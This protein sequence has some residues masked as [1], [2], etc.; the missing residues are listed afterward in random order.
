MMRQVLMIS[1]TVC[2]VAVAGIS[3][4][5][6]QPAAEP[7]IPA[8]QSWEYRFVSLNDLAADAEGDEAEIQAAQDKFNEL[9]R[10]GWEL[11]ENLFRAVVFKRPIS[12]AGSP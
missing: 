10:E 1:L 5:P 8:R 4:L 9:G 2:V 7:E 6:A 3:F 11:S 12:A